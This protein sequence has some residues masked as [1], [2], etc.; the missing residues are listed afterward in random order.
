MFEILSLIL[1]THKF[2]LPLKPEDTICLEFSMKLREYSA[3]DTLKCVWFHVANEIADRKHFQFG[4]K[5]R[6]LGKFPGVP[7][8]IFLGDGKCG[9]I[10]VKTPSNKQTPSQKIF[11]KWCSKH[12]VF[13]HTITSADEGLQKLRDEGILL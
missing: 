2:T 8:Y 10:E 5:I 13:Y 4:K 6:N 11:E 1:P 7:D 9:G 12:N 3:T